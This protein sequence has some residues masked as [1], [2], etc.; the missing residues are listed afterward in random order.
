M[1][2]ITDQDRDRALALAL[3]QI[4]QQFGKGAVMR[5]G[6]EG[7]APA[8]VIPTGALSLDVALGIGGLPRGRVVEIYGPES[9]GKTTLALHAVANTQAAGGIAAFIDAEHALD[10]GYARAIGVDTDNLLVAQVDSGE[11]ALEITDVLIRSGALGIIVIDSVAALVPR[12]EIE[13]EMGESHVGLQA[14]LMSQALRK[15]AGAVSSSKTTVIFINQLREKIGIL[16]GS[17]ETTTGGR[18]LRFYASV[19]LDI[20]RIEALK[21]G[22]DSIGNRTRVKVVKNKCLA[23]GTRVFD[24]STGSTHRIEDIVDGSLAVQVA[25][26]DKAGVL[27]V[28]PVVGWF[29]QGEQDVMGLRLLDGTDLWTTPDHRVLTE[30]GWIPAGV[31]RPGDR[32]ARPREFLGFGQAQPI[33]PAHARMLGYLIGAGNVDGTTLTGFIDISAALHNDAVRIVSDLGCTAA[34]RPDS[35]EVSFS[36]RTGERNGILQLCHSSG[37]GAKPA[38][39][40]QIPAPFFAPDVSAEMGAGVLFGLF[41]TAGWVGG[42]RNHTIR[43]G[44]EVESEQLA[45]QIHW[46]LLRW[47]IGSSVRCRGRAPRAEVGNSR[48]VRG[49]YA[50]WEVRIAGIDDA[51]AF[52]D[53]IPTW[54]PRGRILVG[55]LAATERRLR[56][57]QRTHI[58]TTVTTP[59]VAHLRARGVSTDAAI[60]L[61]AENASNPRGGMQQVRCVGRLWRDHLESL[62]NALDD[63][64]LRN[65]LADQLTY[66]AVQEVLP[67]RR[68]RTFDVEVDELHNLVADGV[69]VHNCAPPLK[70][71]EFDILY[72]HGISRE[73]S[74]VD[75]GVEHGI[76]HKSGAWYTYEGSQL[77]QGKENARVFLRDSPDLA[78]EIEKRLKDRLGVGPKL[79]AASEL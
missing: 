67:I 63:S 18:A 61:I 30:R 73:G 3:S 55:A 41:E 5:L 29:D 76:V 65:V 2:S 22:S 8:G 70:Q 10:P 56:R 24:P 27:H 17:P 79:D 14:R 40:R 77:G 48:P 28:R 7:R 59:I 43:L 58:P 47:G 33:P 1:S 64:F 51:S 23:Q 19:R 34:R 49:K 66:A 9:S 32:V 15:L 35:I 60:Q 37:V 69:V 11:Q 75:M 57:S 4:E 25:A 38:S 45:N 39:A 71:A 74:L 26:A 31:L 62:A 72:D 53:A 46:L 78:A 16:F 50:C 54:G 52:A 21:D 12:A 6:D 44:Y 68:S 42:R 36:H 13:G 20:R